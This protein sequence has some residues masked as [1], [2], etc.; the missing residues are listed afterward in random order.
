MR[1]HSFKWKTTFFF[2]PCL[3]NQQM[4]ISELGEMFSMSKTNII[5]GTKN[6]SASPNI[7]N[8]FL[9]F[10]HFQAKKL[11]PLKCHF[12]FWQLLFYFQ[13]FRL[14]QNKIIKK[15]SFI[16]WGNKF[17]FETKSIETKTKTT[18]SIYLSEW[19]W[20]ARNSIARQSF[21]RHFW[22]QINCSTQNISTARIQFILAK[23]DSSKW[24]SSSWHFFLVWHI[25]WKSQFFTY[26]NGQ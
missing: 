10:L 4:A 16:F 24:L 9:Y 19:G 22:Q 13:S 11:W 21:A 6:G 26:R 14:D 2:V 1:L 7:G 25:N 20:T 17:K 23:P 5:F 3:P 8:L 15:H 12:Y 18:F